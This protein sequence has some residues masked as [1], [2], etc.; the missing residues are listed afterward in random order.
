M[1]VA[2]LFGITRTSAPRRDGLLPQRTVR[3]D[4]PKPPVFGWGLRQA[5]GVVDSDGV[6]VERLDVAMVLAVEVTRFRIQPQVSLTR[7][8]LNAGRGFRRGMM[9]RVLLHLA[10]CLS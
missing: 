3:N 5:F 7:L 1:S 9:L 2:V 6:E 10:Q 8:L 4:K